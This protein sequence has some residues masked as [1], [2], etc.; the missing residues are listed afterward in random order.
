MDTR[1]SVPVLILPSSPEEIL[2]Q[3]HRRRA[4]D[5]PDRN[6]R[7]LRGGL[8]LRKTFAPVSPAA[9]PFPA[10]IGSLLVARETPG[11]HPDLEIAACLPGCQVT[12]ANTP[13]E[14][15]QIL[16]E[17]EFPVDLLLVV[18]S[19]A[20]SSSAIALIRKALEI[21]PGLRVVMMVP[22]AHRV[23][24]P[25]GYEAGATSIVLSDISE[26]ALTV[27]LKQSLSAAHA[28]RRQELHR[29][30]RRER[31][32][33]DSLLRRR[34][35]R[36]KSWVSAGRRKQGLMAA[37]AV[38]VALLIG[39]GFASTL[40]AFYRTT[41]RYEAMSN[42]LL[43]GITSSRRSGGPDVEKAVQRWSAVQQV[44]LTREAN[45]AAR[46]YYQDHLQELRRQA[47]SRI[48]SSS[49]PVY[50]PLPGPQEG[51]SGRAGRAWAG[52]DR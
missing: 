46:R 4:S 7:R 13:E 11:G 44:E 14:T 28:A 42:R 41:D 5:F 22:P 1:M 16:G 32:A 24:I 45:E 19:S 38:A 33:S 29:R 12:Q 36:F 50:S 10:P 8:G 48:V 25:S 40:Q 3:R 9:G 23:D 18:R 52:Y 20:P 26:A 27:F 31:H 39:I 47:A 37:T 34:I 30:E 21:R 15:L 6:D 17:K 51:P 35:R 43:E 2:P 49:E